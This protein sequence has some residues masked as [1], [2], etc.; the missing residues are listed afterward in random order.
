MKAVI[1]TLIAAIIVVNNSVGT[2]RSLIG[3]STESIGIS[4]S[5]NNLFISPSSDIFQKTKS[6]ISFSPE[7]IICNPSGIEDYYLGP[8]IPER[9]KVALSKENTSNAMKSKGVTGIISTDF[10]VG[11]IFNYT[12][13]H[14]YIKSWASRD[15]VKNT[16]A[17]NMW[18]ASTD[19]WG[20]NEAPDTGKYCS[21]I[22]QLGQTSTEICNQICPECES[23]DP[24]G[25]DPGA[26]GCD[27][28]NYL[29]LTGGLEVAMGFRIAGGHIDDDKPIIAYF[30]NIQFVYY[31]IPKSLPPR[32]NLSYNQSKNTSGDSRECDV[33]RCGNAQTDVGDPINVLTG[34]FNYSYTDLSL[35]TIAG[36]L[37]LQRSYASQATDTAS[38]P[39]DMSP[40]WIHNQDVRLL[41]E[42]DTVW[43]KGHTLNQY[44]FDV[45]GDHL[46]DP[47]NGVLAELVYSDGQYLLTTP[48]QSIYV[49]SE[50]GRFLSWTNERGYGFLY[51]YAG[52]RLDRVTEPVSGRYLQFNYLAGAL[53]SVTD[54][55]NR[56]VSYIYDGNGNLT[57]V[58]D[59]RGNT[60]G[61]AYNSD[62]QIITVLA[63]GAPPEVLLVIDYDDEGRAFEQHDG[64]GNRLA[65]IDFNPDGSS[66]STDANG[67]PTNYK[68]D[69]R[70]VVTRTET[71]SV[72]SF[73]GY[74]IDRGYDHNF[75]L[76]SIRGEDDESAT[77]FRWST[78][79]ANLLE[80]DD[81]AN[82]FTRFSY[83]SDNH[84]T[85]V[86]VGEF[87]EDEDTGEVEEL[88]FNWQDLAYNGPLLE[89]STE[90]SSQGDVTTTYTYTTVADAPQ[91]LNLLKSITDALTHQTSF[92]YDAFGQLITITDA[93]NNQTYFTY[94]ATGQVETVTDALGRVTFFEYDPSNAVTSIIENYDT[95]HMHNEENQYNLSST[96][97]YDLQGRLETIKDTNDLLTSTTIYN[98]AGRIHQLLDALN[99]STT[100]SYK[101]D[102][103]IDSIHIAPDYLTGYRYDELGRVNEIRDSLDH[104]VTA[105]TYNPDGT[106]ATET[107]AAGLVTSYTYDALHR[108]TQVSDNAGHM[109][110]T[111][112]DAYGDVTSITDAL[113]RVTKYEYADPGRLTAVIENYL[114]EPT[115]DYDINATNI[116]TEYTYDLLGNLVTIKDADGHDTTYTY[117]NLYQLES[118]TDP[119]GHVTGYTYDE[120]GNQK[121]LT[122]PDAS[123]T[124]FDYDLV[125]RLTGIDY[126][127]G[128]NPDV[129]FTHNALSQLT[130]MYDSLGHTSWTYTL[131]GQPELVTDPFNRSIAYLYDTLGNRTRLTYPGGRMVNYVYNA[132]GLLEEVLDG[133][134]T[135][136]A[137]SYDDADRLLSETYANGVATHFSYDLSSQ[138]TGINHVLGGHDL[139]AY[140]YTYD[141]VGNLTQTVETGRYP[142]YGY[143]PV[144]EK[145]ASG[146]ENLQFFNLD[147][148]D[149][150][151]LEDGMPEP[152]DEGYPAPENTSYAPGSFWQQILSFFNALFTPVP[153]S[154][155]DAPS[156][157]GQD[158]TINYTYDALDRLKSASYNNGLYYGYDYDKVGNRSTETINGVTTSYFYDV[159]NRLSSV[160]GT[161]YTWNDNGS[162]IND[163]LVN[164]S[165]NSA[166][167]LSYIA[168][169]HGSFYFIYDGL[170]NRYVQSTGGHT[171]FYSLDIAAGLTQVLREGPTT[172]LYGLGIIGQ[173]T[174][175]EMV[176]ALAD[177]LGSIR[178]LV[179]EDQQVTLLKSYDPFGNTLLEQGTGGSSFGYTGEQMDA[180]GLEYLRARYYDP[181]TGRFITADP[182]P[183]ALS[184][185][186]TQNAYPYVI[187]NPL[188]YTD[189]S[190]ELAPLLMA[191]LAA[192]A[193]ALVGGGLNIASQCIGSYDIKTCLKC[194]DWGKVSVAASAGAVAGLVGFGVG[195]AFE[196]LGVRLLQTMIGGFYAGLFSGQAY[197]ATELALTGRLDQAGTVLFQPRD[198]Y[199]DGLLGAAGSAVG[200]GVGQIIKPLTQKAEGVLRGR[201]GGKKHRD[202]TELLTDEILNKKLIPKGEYMVRTP[203]GTKS[204]RFIDVAALDEY[205]NPVTYYQVGKVTKNGFPILRERLAVSDILNFG[206]IKIPLIFIPMY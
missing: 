32:S 191:G 91:P 94:D 140:S 146:L 178:Q 52:A 196:A 101:E 76:T 39:T 64:A 161:N 86:V 127:G 165:Y 132:D 65:H 130:D 126:P 194:L 35:Q 30:D 180:S 152:L 131:L 55:A 49:F 121:T 109:V 144:I 153:V 69:C 97:G 142:N 157:P 200:Y 134:E 198:M 46:Y 186:A 104:L 159:A 115:P 195:L 124:E 74:F 205:G 164:Y 61:Y 42:D 3:A 189:P 83:D 187:N 122:R 48:S 116:R 17:T 193:G 136:V 128:P 26:L 150:E 80:M 57:G 1:N 188:S 43:F 133:T 47:Y 173:E 31:G 92:T 73:P 176:Y 203:G 96:F 113:G 14:P 10:Y 163:G 24:P 108:V 13:L 143:L 38:H 183:G 172:Y 37:S 4:D 8:V 22:P 182:Y 160:N 110:T 192:G 62:H 18:K 129:S 23:Y 185:P 100:Y 75:N 148:F 25:I 33:S 171:T 106:V 154:A 70:G 51:S 81:Q 93:E 177:R 162:L 5:N 90:S 166:G 202:L 141:L 138:L 99:N 112:Y 12:I 151:F 135:L 174:N 63:P 27:T 66:T 175:G 147:N 28:Q 167:L 119:L 67:I 21:V 88:E 118:V 40:G 15:G 114:A 197:R 71:P 107:D 179:T 78:D 102:G 169:P 85:S 98:D 45:I 36:P 105:Y 139:A 41:F 117:T 120:L 44:R 6:A 9:V 82:Y 125:N 50:D 95:V 149:L 7:P 156:N 204:Y 77:Q 206:T 68:P 184:L 58:T 87:I 11:A 137:Y 72:G 168:T 201:L 84:L 20:L 158:Q 59:V 2:P 54:S 199:M 123:V 170:G 60:W 79:G 181:G 111:S 53:Q 19:E 145:G 34:N 29:C 89:S 190:G 16:E 103:A 56:Q 155:M